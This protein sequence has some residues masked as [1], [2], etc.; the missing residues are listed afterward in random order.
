MTT[1]LDSEHATG[2]R[3]SAGGSA[4]GEQVRRW[5]FWPTLAAIAAVGLALR[6]LFVFG[7]GRT[8][9][10]LSDAFYFHLGGQALADG[11][12]F[13][14]PYRYAAGELVPAA[15]HPPLYQV[16]LAVPSLFGLDSVRSHQLAS[17]LLGA[18]MVVVVGLV[19]RR[20]AGR[21]AGL[22]AGAVAAVYPNLWINDAMLMSESMYALTIALVLWA[23]YGAWQ[24][25]DTSGAAVLGAAVALAALTRAEA[26]LLLVLLVVPLFGLMKAQALRRKVV[27]VGTALAVALAVMAPWVGYNLIRFDRPVLLSSGAGHVLAAANCDQTYSGN[28]LGYWSQDCLFGEPAQGDHSVWEAAARA[29]GIDYMTTH[30]G[31]VPVVVLARVGRLWELYR[32]LQGVELSAYAEHRGLWPT[33]LALVS[34]YVLLLIGAYGLVV[35]WRRKVTVVPMVALAAMV[36][37]TA[38]VSFGITRYRV[39]VDVGLAVLAGVAVDQWLRNRATDAAYS[40]ASSDSSPATASTPTS[41]VAN[42]ALSRATCSARDRVRSWRRDSSK[43]K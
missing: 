35:L 27:L 31:E 33:R 41:R 14:D 25:A 26:V 5:P 34:Y 13:V 22:V 37:F 12:G 30:L 15:G 42:S 19:G 3:R 36:T 20:L 28:L 17:T 8:F 29:E 43:E 32:P 16:Y 39:P 23:A 2:P 7:S 11:A 4:P 21:R 40:T 18:T 9:E 38:A 10:F 6:V 1:E 24:R